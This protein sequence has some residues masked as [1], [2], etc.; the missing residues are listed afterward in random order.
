[1][2]CKNGEGR[3]YKQSAVLGGGQNVVLKVSRRR[4]SRSKPRSCAVGPRSKANI[5]HAEGTVLSA[6]LRPEEED[7]FNN[8]TKMREPRSRKFSFSTPNPTGSGTVSK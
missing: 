3:V 7:A 2:H 5:H 1:M 8:P 4:K 6:L